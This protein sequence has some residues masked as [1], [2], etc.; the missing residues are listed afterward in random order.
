MGSGSYLSKT[1]IG[2]SFPTSSMSDGTIM[3]EYDTSLSVELSVEIKKR[4]T[5]AVSIMPTLEGNVPSNGMVDHSSPIQTFRTVEARLAVL[6]TLQFVG[7]LCNNGDWGD[8]EWFHDK[9]PFF[10]LRQ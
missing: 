8:S 1:R 9:I 10:D 4:N 3:E 2:P 6:S 7:M 5:F